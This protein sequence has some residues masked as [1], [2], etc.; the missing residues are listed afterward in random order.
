MSDKSEKFCPLGKY[1]K[2]EIDGKLTRR[3]AHCGC[4][5]GGFARIHYNDLGADIS[6]YI[7]Q[8]NFYESCPVCGYAAFYFIKGGPKQNAQNLHS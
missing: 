7:Y 1:V 6:E 2:V 4:T 3:K 5:T 8:E